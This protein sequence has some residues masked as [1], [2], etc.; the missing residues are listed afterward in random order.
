[1]LPRKAD[2]RAVAAQSVNLL[3]LLRD[4]W[5]QPTFVHC[6]SLQRPGRACDFDWVAT[7]SVVGVTSAA[8]ETADR[9]ASDATEGTRTRAF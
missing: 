3:A 7:V 8:I 5:G 1:M 4:L 2:C 6:I 9:A